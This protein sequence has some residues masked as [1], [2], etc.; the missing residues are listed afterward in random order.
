MPEKDLSTTPNTTDDRLLREVVR[1]N[2]VTMALTLGFLGGLAI[3]VL[4]ILLVLKGGERV[5]PHLALLGQFFPGYRVTYLGSVIG[6]A[7][8]FVSGFAGGFII[9]WFYNYIVELSG[10]YNS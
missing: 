3:F 9:G 7:Y 2:A 4:T 6:F 10:R 1:V 5:G 8:G